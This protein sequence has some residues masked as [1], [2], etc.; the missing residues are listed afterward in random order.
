MRDQHVQA[1]VGE[2]VYEVLEKVLDGA[3]VRYPDEDRAE[4]GRRREAQ[5]AASREEL[6]PVHVFPELGRQV[7]VGLFEQAERCLAGCDL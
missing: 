3:R 2:F 6:D 7:R 1:Q 5:V 4:G